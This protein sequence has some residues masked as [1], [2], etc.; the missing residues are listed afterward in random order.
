MYCQIAKADNEGQ[1]SPC[2]SI[3]G[4]PE[5]G[6]MDQGLEVILIGHFDRIIRRIHPL[7]RQL[8]RFPAADRTHRR[9]RNIHLLRLNSSGGKQGIFFFE[10]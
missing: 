1:F 7:H 5:G 6:L 3:Q 8:Q 4:K 9:C 2:L 10:G